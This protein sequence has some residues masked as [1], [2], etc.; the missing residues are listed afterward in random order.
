MH[1]HRA[2]RYREIV[3]FKQDRNSYLIYYNLLCQGGGEMGLVTTWSLVIQMPFYCCLGHVS[4]GSIYEI[5]I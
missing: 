3:H 1:R 2:Q 4:P 5:I